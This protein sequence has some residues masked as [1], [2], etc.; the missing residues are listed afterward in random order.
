VFLSLHTENSDI[1]EMQRIFD[2]Q[3]TAFRLDLATTASERLA[4]L[5]NLKN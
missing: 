1:A 4:L 2:M 3:K 5:D